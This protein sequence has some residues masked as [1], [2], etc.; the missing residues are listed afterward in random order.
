MLTENDLGVKVDIEDCS[1]S[2]FHICQVMLAYVFKVDEENLVYKVE[3]AKI[4]T[5]Y[6]LFDLEL[7]I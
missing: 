6:F 7:N 1:M 3:I 4:S 5:Y 2:K